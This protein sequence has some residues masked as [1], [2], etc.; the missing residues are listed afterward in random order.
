MSWKMVVIAL[1]VV[2]CLGILKSERHDLVT[3]LRDEGGLCLYRMGRMEE[4]KRVRALKSRQAL[5]VELAT[6]C[7]AATHHLSPPQSSI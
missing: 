5:A 4:V 7:R 3:P 2:G 1:Q 6:L